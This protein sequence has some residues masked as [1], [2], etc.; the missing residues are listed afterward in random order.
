VTSR[1]APQE[2]PDATVSAREAE[3]LAALGEHLTNAEIAARLVI[4][5]RTV[6]SHV[7]SLLRKL[8]VGDRRGL[9]AAA[10]RADLRQHQG[11]PPLAPVRLQARLPAPLTSFV[12]RAAELAELATA[13]RSYRLVTAVGPGG[14][15]KTRLALRVAAELAG[16]VADG[17][18]FVDLVPVTDA[19]LVPPAIAAALGLGERVART[20]A[21]TV[22]SWL[23]DREVLLVLDNCEQVGDGLAA[24]LERLLVACPGVTVLATGRSRLLVPFEQV[25]AVSGLAV[26]APDGARGDAVALFLER[27]AAAGAP[28]P[29]QDLPRVAA[30][31][32]E[33]D[34]T[35]LAIELAAARAPSLG[36]DGL[37]VGLADRLRLLAGGGRVDDRHRSLRSTLDWSYDLLDDVAQAVL[38]RVSVFAGDF[39]AAAAAQVV[40]GWAP[41][42][43]GE[44]P[45][46][47]AAL[48]EQSLLMPTAGT[49]ATRYRALETVRQYAADRLAAAGE[50]APAAG[51]HLDRCLETAAALEAAP[52]RDG[53]AWRAAFDDAAVELRAAIGRPV[54]DAGH[55]RRLRRLA[56]TL[57]GLAFDRGT[58]GDAQRHYEW[59]AELADDDADRAEALHRAAGAAE[60]RHLGNEALR[61][62][63]A[64]TQARLRAGDRPGAAVQLARAGELIRRGPGMMQSLATPAEVE[65]LLAQARELAGDD[66][67]ALARILIAD[68]FRVDGAEP[69]APDLAARA[70]EITTR[71]D[72]P[73]A[74]SAALD[75]LTSVQL[76]RDDV[77]EAA[78]NTRRRLELLA[79]LRMTARAGLEFSDAVNMATDCALAIGDL[80]AAHRY[81]QQASLLPFQREEPH[82]ATSR[83]MLSCTFAGDWD[84][85]LALGE[86]FIEGFE[87]AGRPLAGILTRGAWAAATVC[88]FRGDE[89]ARARW[90]A[91]VDAVNLPLRVPGKL[92]AGVVLDSMLLLHRGRFA[93]AVE[94]LALPPRHQGGWHGGMWRPWQA[95]V[96]AEAAVLAGRD[97]ATDRIA[98]ARAVA[99][100]SPVSAGLIRRA[101]ALLAGDEAGLLAAAGLLQAAGCRYDWARS[102]ALT[103]GPQRA[104]GEA[105]L[106]ELGTA[107]PVRPR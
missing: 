58:P 94:R 60:V 45:A 96:L 57:A 74:V 35:A 72:D 48:A 64:A 36:L 7:S 49:G 1:P 88:G 73:L 20:A 63:R 84:E 69:D 89:A 26:E 92:S 28:V 54:A 56:L 42:E 99:S 50:T 105:V 27:A 18:C 78:A 33:L 24:V 25:F 16:D 5:V 101:E 40:G 70:L 55:R 46:V 71:L 103:D 31:C 37:Q 95:A 34:G 93:A 41:V 2:A 68:A 23:A 43:D 79:P 53:A 90:L 106:A 107:P 51:R 8:G 6:E 82:L 44:V 66:E 83:L 62:R 12:G 97:D 80:P 65:A 52:D 21:E 47:L 102:L 10:A 3:V 38:R 15:G 61:L 104:R 22:H 17:V 14:V 32:A 81:A 91:I 77:Q 86:R 29:P 13:L 98:Q 30:I 87:R 39:P 75:A 11:R 85:V 9:V 19:E 67:A 4:S 59:A 76:A 100:G